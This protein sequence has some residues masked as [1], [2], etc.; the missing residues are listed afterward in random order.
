MPYDF[1]GP[2]MLTAMLHLTYQDGSEEW[3]YSDETWRVGGDPLVFA[4]IFDGAR[5]DASVLPLSDPRPV[6]PVDGPGGRDAP[7]AASAR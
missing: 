4:S 7:H 6:D 3:I 5:Y 2:K 1:S